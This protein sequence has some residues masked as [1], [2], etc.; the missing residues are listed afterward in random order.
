MCRNFLR[1]YLSGEFEPEELEDEAPQVSSG[2]R[3]VE[4]QPTDND[5]QAELSRAA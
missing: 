4:P 3:L 5:E 2:L 1:A